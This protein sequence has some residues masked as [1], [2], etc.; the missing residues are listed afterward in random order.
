MEN[1]LFT[2]WLLAVSLQINRALRLMPPTAWE[3]D[4]GILLAKC[5]GEELLQLADTLGIV[6]VKKIQLMTEQYPDLGDQLA[7]EGAQQAVRD[8]VSTSGFAS[9][10]DRLR[11]MVAWATPPSEKSADSQLE[12][13]VEN[14]SN[15]GK[16]YRTILR[17][18]QDEEDICDNQG[19]R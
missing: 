18:G 6:D 19:Q 8:W 7:H 16:T 4:V 10:L 9:R 17:G 1:K 5:S 12:W 11:L 13:K 14:V 3:R 2:G 15:N